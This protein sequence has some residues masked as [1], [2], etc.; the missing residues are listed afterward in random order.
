MADIKQW[1]T[2]NRPQPLAEL[3]GTNYSSLYCETGNK[4]GQP[5]VSNQCV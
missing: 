3:I 2:S 4:A 1:L 5:D